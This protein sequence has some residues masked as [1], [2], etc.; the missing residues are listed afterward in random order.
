MRLSKTRA[1]TQTPIRR[2]D[3]RLL[4]FPETQG[5]PARIYLFAGLAEVF[6]RPPLE[7]DP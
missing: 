3:G 6:E 4:A 7:P 1:F 2:D 5:V